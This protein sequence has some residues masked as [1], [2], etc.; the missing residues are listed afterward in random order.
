ME[1]SKCDGFYTVGYS[2]RPNCGEKTGQHV[3]KT[4]YRHRS[5]IDEDI[6]E[7]EPRP[8]QDLNPIKI[9]PTPLLCHKLFRLT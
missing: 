7:V 9:V 4:E 2:Y 6:L 3:P 8:R 1:S 5:R